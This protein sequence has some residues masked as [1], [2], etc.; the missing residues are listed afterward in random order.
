MLLTKSGEET[1]NNNSNE[2][3]VHDWC[4]NKQIS[5][6]KCVNVTIVCGYQLEINMFVNIWDEI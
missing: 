5:H 4:L 3:V 1:I 2:L 6:V